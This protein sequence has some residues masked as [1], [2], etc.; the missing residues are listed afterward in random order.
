MA[1]LMMRTCSLCCLASGQGVDSEL[2]GGLGSDGLD[3]SD[4]SDKSDEKQSTIRN[5]FCWV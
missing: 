4:K 1:L 2:D 3:G 5:C